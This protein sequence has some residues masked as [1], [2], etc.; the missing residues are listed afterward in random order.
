MYCIQGVWQADVG[1][2]VN[3][4]LRRAWACADELLKPLGARGARYLNVVVAGAAFPANPGDPPPPATGIFSPEWPVV[5]R[6]PL[7]V[8]V[9][10][11]VLG[12]LER[13]LRRAAGETVYE[14]VPD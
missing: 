10:E 5:S 7:S 1:I 11:A 3:T 13:E 6:G 2:F 9:D 8:G 12:S 14:P 4:P